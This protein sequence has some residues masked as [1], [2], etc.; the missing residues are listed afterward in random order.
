MIVEHLLSKLIESCHETCWQPL[1]L[2]LSGYCFSTLLT[3]LSCRNCLVG[4]FSLATG[5]RQSR[6]FAR[7]SGISR[8]SVL[9]YLKF[10]WWKCRRNHSSSSLA[11]CNLKLFLS[12]EL[13]KVKETYFI[14]ML[15]VTLNGDKSSQGS[16]RCYTSMRLSV[17]L[18]LEQF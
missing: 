11:D 7:F 3:E 10:Q 5:L 18:M 6:K 17:S 9:V 1:E 13:S 14:L 16:I 2:S 4:I 8:I 12:L 15:P